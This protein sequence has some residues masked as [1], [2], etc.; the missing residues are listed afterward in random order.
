MDEVDFTVLA[1]KSVFTDMIDKCPPAETCRDAFDR[2]AKATIKMATSTGGFGMSSQNR[3]RQAPRWSSGSDA[4]LAKPK[5]HRSHPSD[6]T[7]FLVDM[8]MSDNASTPSLSIGGDVGGQQTSPTG[9]SK[10]YEADNYSMRPQPRRSGSN[11][12][13]AH[14]NP[15]IGQAIDTSLG[16]PPRQSRRAAPQQDAMRGPFL[17]PSFG[18]QANSIDFPDGQSMDFLQNLDTSSN[19]EFGNIDQA[20]LD[21]VFGMNWEGFSSDF[22][23][24]QQVNPFGTFFFGGPQGGNGSGF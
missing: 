3:N 2:T 8:S 1:A 5:S 24:G 4:P 15:D 19:G 22:A 6:Q 7:T 18:D 10:S 14:V 20:Q 17:S 12:H 21:P 9:T 23:D 13:E 16:T 11:H